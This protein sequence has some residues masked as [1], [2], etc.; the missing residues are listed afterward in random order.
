MA[1]LGQYEFPEIGLTDSIELARRIH[2]ELRGKVRRDA[3][4]IA[5]R[6][7]P[8][9]GGFGRWVGALRMWGLATGGTVISL[10]PDGIRIVAHSNAL[11]A[12]ELRRKLAASVPLFNELHD[13]L[14]DSGVDQSVLAAMLQEISGAETEN[15][16]YRVALVERIFGGV[17]GYLDGSAD[18]EV[19]ALVEEQAIAEARESETLSHGWIELRYDDGALRVKETMANLDVL[20]A[21]L[22]SRRDRLIGDE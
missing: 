17:R 13:R 2:E 21:T 8:E 16:M 7:S 5:L 10:T 14:G 22:E 19:F 6:M 1:K 4:A 11:E 15:V 12:A 9:G 18:A 3:L 20:I